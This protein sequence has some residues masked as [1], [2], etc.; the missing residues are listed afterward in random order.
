VNSTSPRDEWPITP[1][2]EDL[3]RE[4]CGGD[5]AYMAE[6]RY[7]LIVG[8]VYQSG[9]NGQFH[10]NVSQPWDTFDKASTAYCTLPK[11]GPDMGKDKIGEVR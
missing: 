10:P 3:K 1:F 4:D 7:K 2:G 5:A 6:G 9:W 11:D 8:R